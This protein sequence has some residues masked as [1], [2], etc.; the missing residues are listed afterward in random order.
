MDY[1]DIRLEDA[2]QAS[3]RLLTQWLSQYP[4]DSIGHS[5]IANEIKRREKMQREWLKALFCIVT[6]GATLLYF[7][8]R[9]DES[10]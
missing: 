3:D 1:P 7:L 10:P 8:V 2:E 4:P 6:V 9:G 5:V